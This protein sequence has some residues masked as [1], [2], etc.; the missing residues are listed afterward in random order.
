MKALLQRQE[1]GANVLAFVAQ[2]TGVRAG[3]LQR[4]LPCFS[5]A[6]GKEDAVKSGTLGEAKCEL[7]L[8]LVKVE[9]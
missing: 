9:V 5:T 7:G 1:P 4:S 8:T 3:Q 2:H 6:V